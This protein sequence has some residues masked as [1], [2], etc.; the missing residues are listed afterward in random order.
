MR[1]SRRILAASVLLAAS[2]GFVNVVLLRA[3][4]TPV[5]H[6]TGAVSALSADVGDADLGH[7]LRVLSLVAS[8]IFGAGISG[9]IIGSDTVRFGRSYGVAMLVQGA[10]LGLATVLLLRGFSLGVLAAS[11]S[12]GVQNAMASTYGG[13]IIRTTHVTGVATDFGFMLGAWARRRRVEMWQLL[14]L[15]ML[16]AH[17]FAGGVAGAVASARFGVISLAAPSA[18]ALV[19]GGAYFTYRLRRFSGP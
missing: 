11:V 8:F 10:L 4:L 15:A 3:E 2:A 1:P 14:H 13:L 17:F 6:V 12:A 9:F 5:T 7:G 16:L 18:L 19:L